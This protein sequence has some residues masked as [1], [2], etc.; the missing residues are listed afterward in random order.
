MLRS[1][2]N[3]AP[4]SCSTSTNAEKIASVSLLAQANAGVCTSGLSVVPRQVSESECHACCGLDMPE[5]A[6]SSCTV[7]S[8]R[9]RCCASASAEAVEPLLPT[10]M[11]A[12]RTCPPSQK[13]R[14]KLALAA[15]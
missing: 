4:L 7:C 11:T 15:S 10:A 1:N 9:P 14:H 12:P 6:Q 13:T 2:E 5:C 3:V 8:A